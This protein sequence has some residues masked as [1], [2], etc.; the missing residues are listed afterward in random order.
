MEQAGA[1]VPEN[2]G[3]RKARDEDRYLFKTS[4][5]PLPVPAL[6]DHDAMIVNALWLTKGDLWLELTPDVI[7]YCLTALRQS[8]VP[9][10]RSPKKKRK[11]RGSMS[12]KRKARKNQSTATDEED[13]AEE[14]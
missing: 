12:P 10:P 1:V 7:R 8:D 9:P 6:E 5:V 2:H 13:P 14:D 4:Q 3:F 11:R